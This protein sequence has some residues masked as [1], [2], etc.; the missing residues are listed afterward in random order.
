[1]ITLWSGS[2]TSIPSGWVLCDGTNGT[3]DLRDKF[4]VGANTGTGDTVYPGLSV[5][6]TGGNADATLVAHNHTGTTN[7]AGNHS[8]GVPTGFGDDSPIT[9]ARNG[10]PETDIST[11][12]AGN[13]SHTLA[14][15]F[16]GAPATDANLPPYYA[17]AYIMKL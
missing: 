12:V 5:G 2:V 7:V 17:L 1:V 9:S 16:E 8:H 4:V 6:A 15:S 14:I 10:S 3:P 13:H 11:T